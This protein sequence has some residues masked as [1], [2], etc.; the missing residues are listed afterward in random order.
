MT[1]PRKV[2]QKRL[3]MEAKRYGKWCKVSGV[4]FADDGQIISFELQTKNYKKNGLNWDVSAGAD[5]VYEIR[6][7]ERK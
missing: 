7:K 1:L 5:F 3:F 6:F 4:S 2:N